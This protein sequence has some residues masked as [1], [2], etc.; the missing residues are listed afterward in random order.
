MSRGFSAE[1][2]ARVRAVVAEEVNRLRVPGVAVGVVA[3]DRLVYAEGFGFA[4]I[5]SGRRQDPNLRQR[6]GS[7]TKTMVGLCAMALVD[8]GRLAL[9]DRL[10]DHV[11]ELAFHG[12]GAGVTVRHLLTHTSGIGEVAMP[13]EIQNTRDTLWSDQADSD[14]LGL[15]ARG[16]TIDVPPGTKWSYANLGFALLGEIV[17][18]AEGAPIAEVLARRIFAPLGMTNSDLLDLPHPDLTT[19]YHRAPGE[20]ER[21]LAARAGVTL[22]DEPTVDGLN[23]RGA[24]LHIRGGGAAGAVQSTVPDMARYA[25]ALLRG[26]AG[27]VRPETFAAMVAPQW[28]PDERM[29]S[30]GL[31]FARHARFGRRIFGHGGGVLG[32]WNST[33][34]IIP[35][36]DLALI[37]H[38]N[39]Y[40]DEFVQLQS[41]LLAATLDASAPRLGGGIASEV[42]AAAPGVYEAGPGKLT[43]FRVSGGT[44]RVLI[45]AD[46][47]GLM[48]YSRRGKWKNG[49]RMHPAEAGDPGFFHLADDA[50]EPARIA[51]IRDEQGRVSGLRGDGLMVMVRTDQVAQWI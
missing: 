44:G 16:L 33:L 25:R 22:P 37:V 47:D 2:R 27:I 50:M 11:P 6:I 14:V 17:A 31:S 49:V 15:F 46:A 24:F 34:H 10:A 4:D 32:G 26:G 8:E 12:D 36:E 1:D 48:L 20:D 40:F 7:I 3:G 42:A 28:C 43:N 18:R 9:T 30:W 39:C 51:L 29:D 38:A 35:S 23:I 19:G 21:E 5:E 45:K 13:D 41:R